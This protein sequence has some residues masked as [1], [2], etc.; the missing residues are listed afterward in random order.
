MDEEDDDVDAVSIPWLVDVA[1]DE[2]SDVDVD[3]EEE[4]A[5]EEEVDDTYTAA[6]DD[7]VNDDDVDVSPAKNVA[8]VNAV[9]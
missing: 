6:D 5:E 8:L 9:R 7:E 4:E 1:N 3:D 2:E